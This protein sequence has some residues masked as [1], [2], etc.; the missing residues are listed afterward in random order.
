YDPNGRISYVADDGTRQAIPAKRVDR[1]ALSP[2]GQQS[3]Y[4]SYTNAKDASGRKLWIAN[5]DGTEPRQ[6]P[7]PCQGCEPGFGVT[8]SHDGTRIAYSVFTPGTQPAKLAIWD[9]T[10]GS[11]QQVFT[12]PPG[13]DGRG[14]TFSPDDKL[15]A[16][17]LATE[18]GEGVATLDPARGIT[19]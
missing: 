5:A 19:S 14:L 11:Q 4:I 7:M 17:N 2:D 3:A 10:T 8:W 1:F 9:V 12:M 15:L 16:M 18:G 13:D 6:V